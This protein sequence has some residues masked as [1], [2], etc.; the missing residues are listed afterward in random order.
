VPGVDFSCSEQ[1]SRVY[2]ECA[3]LLGKHPGPFSFLLSPPLSL[4]P[5]LGLGFSPPGRSLGTLLGKVSNLCFG[6]SPIPVS[7]SLGE[8]QVTVPLIETQKAT[9]GNQQAVE[10]STP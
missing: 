10:M 4:L 1:L 8:P 6:L 5:G 2:T 3:Q 7:L 9:I